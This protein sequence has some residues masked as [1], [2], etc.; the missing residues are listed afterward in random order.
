VIYALFL[1]VV[2]HRDLASVVSRV[3]EEV[4]ILGDP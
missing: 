1:E 3:P 2:I 4:V